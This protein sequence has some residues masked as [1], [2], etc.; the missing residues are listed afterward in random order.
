MCWCVDC[1]AERG[2]KL[3]IRCF[4]ASATQVLTMDPVKR[5]KEE[6]AGPIGVFF[7]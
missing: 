4:K 7:R 3:T 1:A 6:G 2:T 5:T